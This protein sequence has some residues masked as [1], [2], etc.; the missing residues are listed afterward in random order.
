MLL[1]DKKGLSIMIGYVLLIVIAIVMSM[2][3][4]QFIRTYVP[5]DIF[6]CPD[7]VSVF[8]QETIYNCDTEKLNV[9]IKNNG[10]FNV[11]G[12]F[13]HTTTSPEQELAT[14]DLSD[15]IS[16]GG[17]DYRNSILFALG[18]ENLLSTNNLKKTTF[19]LSDVG[20]IY[21]INIVPVRF[22]EEEGKTRFVTCGNA[23]VGE[24]LSCWEEPEACEQNC[25]GRECGLDPVCSEVCLPDD[26][27]TRDPAMV[28]DGTGTCV[29]EE[30]CED[31]CANLGYVCGTWTICGEETI[32]SPGCDVGES[33]SV[34]GQCETSCGDGVPGG[35]EECDDGGTTSGDGCSSDCLIEFCG[36]GIITGTDPNENYGTAN[37]T[38]PEE[39]D[40]GGT[41]S[42]DGCSNICEIQIGWDCI[43]EP[44]T[45][46]LIGGY[47]CEDY[48]IDLSAGYTGGICTS[49]TGQCTSYP[50]TSVGQGDEVF[51]DNNYYCCCA[52]PQ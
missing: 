5:K 28:C 6:Q 14:E 10:R 25:A 45:C 1:Q 16:T 46:E 33:C 11:A 32:C 20:T 42:G 13:I 51:C 15:K 39:C 48:C 36:D 37:V 52:P 43:G 24:V 23:K 2:V 34:N 4:F 17:E 19:D 26:C 22:Q 47:S 44:S 7:G 41:T 3:V 30:E 35:D 12:Y 38:I 21:K 18:S 29:L 31:T 49:N 27:A 40:D 9:T 8:I 50:G